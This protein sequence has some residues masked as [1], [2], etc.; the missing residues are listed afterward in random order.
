[1]GK[2][3]IEECGAI[4]EISVSNSGKMSP[5][6]EGKSAPA[7]AARGFPFCQDEEEFTA[8]TKKISD[9]IID[10]KSPHADDTRRYSYIYLI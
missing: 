1:M 7:L 10:G 9:I 5:I 8:L 6:M 3:S 4:R 2:E